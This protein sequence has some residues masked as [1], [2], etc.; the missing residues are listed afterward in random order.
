MQLPVCERDWWFLQVSGDGCSSDGQLE[1][2]FF[3]LLRKDGTG[4]LSTL[5]GD[6]CLAG[7]EVWVF[8]NIMTFEGIPDALNRKYTAHLRYL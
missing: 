6:S 2:C 3:E 8:H 4:V 1:C 7:I 5:C